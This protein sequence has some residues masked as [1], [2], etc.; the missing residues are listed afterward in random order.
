[1]TEL[2]ID[3]I[4]DVVCPW[5]I[6]GFRRLTEALE[7]L[8]GIEAQ[9]HW[10]P[11]EL[12]PGMPEG[13]QHLGEHMAQKYASTPE[14][15]RQA[16]ERLAKFGAELGFAFDYFDDM[17]IYNTR[18][19]HTLLHALAGDERQTALKLALFATY[20]QRRAD[21]DDPEVLI[22]AAREAGIER[23]EAERLLA[24]DGL[25]AE[26][27]KA[28]QRWLDAGIRGVPAFVVNDAYLIS[29]AQDVTTLVRTLGSIA[30]EAEAAT[31]QS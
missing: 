24:D 1:M 29:G 2:K 19:A 27:V 22:T 16:R 20:F 31:A 11:F 15:S 25:S 10:H 18:P 17:R 4:S 26:V 12:N 5:C 14:Q 28:E 3:I 30:A 7:R 8:D 9:I 6:V 21:L 23:G 13:G